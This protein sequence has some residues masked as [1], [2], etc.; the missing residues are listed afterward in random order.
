MEIKYL[1]NYMLKYIL[2]LTIG[3]LIFILLNHNENFNIGNQFLT[4]ID[5]IRST[6]ISF[7]LDLDVCPSELKSCI[8]LLR[9]RGGACALLQLLKLYAIQEEEITSDELDNIVRIYNL[10][11]TRK[12]V[13][14]VLNILGKNGESMKKILD[15]SGINTSSVECVSVNLA[16]ISLTPSSSNVT[17]YKILDEYLEYNKLYMAYMNL[18]FHAGA[19]PPE[20]SKV[21]AGHSFFIYKNIN[22]DEQIIYTIFDGCNPDL[23]VIISTDNDNNIYNIYSYW[24]TKFNISVEL[25][26]QC[27]MGLFIYQNN[28][29]VCA[30]HVGGGY[31]GGGGGG[32][33]D[34]DR[35]S[36]GAIAPPRI[37]SDDDSER[38]R[39][40][41]E[42]TEI[43]ISGVTPRYVR[44]FNRMIRDNDYTYN[45]SEEILYLNVVS[46]DRRDEIGA[47]FEGLYVE[48]QDDEGNTY[49]RYNG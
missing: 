24:I 45:E 36:G 40:S 1:F 31:G 37:G 27:Y 38:I 30:P 44:Q 10:G 29:A 17:A 25:M 46:L 49:L 43:T 18:K 9:D 15:R 6:S 39:D 7:Y 8:Q 26:K 14:E 28:K 3:I 32:Y 33:S 19:Y 23:Y 21:D 13:L 16:H 5:Q 22:Q 41:I 34:T 2:F 35:Y 20:P 42:D 11:S 48:I 4:D 12:N 47:S